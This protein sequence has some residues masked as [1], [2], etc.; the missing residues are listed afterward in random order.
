MKQNSPLFLSESYIW[1]VTMNKH[2]NANG[3][4]IYNN[5]SNLIYNKI[6]SFPITFPIFSLEI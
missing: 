6:F 5:Q 3:S 4:I 2:S 1:R